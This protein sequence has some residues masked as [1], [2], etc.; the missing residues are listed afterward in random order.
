MNIIEI[1]SE[2][3]FHAETQRILFRGIMH[4][5]YLDSDAHTGT[6]STA[7]AGE[8]G[9]PEI[10]DDALMISYRTL[11]PGGFDV[12]T[13]ADHRAAVQELILALLDRGWTIYPPGPC[14]LPPGNT[15]NREQ[16]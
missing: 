9:A 8:A 5:T 10:P 7:D 3:L 6:A 15:A 12:P 16:T 1:A 11:R 13:L 2:P 4:L 14:T